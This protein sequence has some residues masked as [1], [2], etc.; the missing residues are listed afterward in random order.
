M[1][2]MCD[3]SVLLAL[4]AERHAYHNRCKRWWKGRDHAFPLLICREVQIALLRLLS[5]EAVMSQDVMTLPHAW[6]LYASLLKCG[7]FARVLEPRGL[8]VE[9]ERLCRPYKRSPK[10]VMDA[11]LAAF[12]LAGGYTLVT[13]DEAFAN[14]SGLPLLIPPELET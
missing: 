1:R 9:W 12:A 8:D 10:V 6:A 14:F 13:L 11:Y 4:V 7:G 3:I 2:Q 5:T